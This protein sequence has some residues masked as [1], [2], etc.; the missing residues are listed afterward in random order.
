MYCWTTSMKALHVG[1][2]TP[3]HSDSRVIFKSVRKRLAGF[4]FS[5]S[6]QS[7]AMTNERLSGAVV[8]T[9]LDL[10]EESTMFSKTLVSQ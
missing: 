10:L 8:L 5:F 1:T 7:P 2:A 9:G 4:D 6:M 3:R